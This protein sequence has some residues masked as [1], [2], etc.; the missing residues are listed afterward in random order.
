MKFGLFC[1]FS[2]FL[3][4]S[5]ISKMPHIKKYHLDFC[6]PHL[7]LCVNNTNTNSCILTEIAHD[8]LVKSMTVLTTKRHLN[9][10]RLNINPRSDIITKDIVCSFPPDD[11]VLSTS[12]T[13]IATAATP[14]TVGITSPPTKLLNTTRRLS[15]SDAD[16]PLKGRLVLRINVI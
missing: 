11:I 6:L 7:D 10:R 2:Q 15:E 9:P 12:P 1:C 3:L 16:T 5:S 4:K 8:S 14:S 13:N